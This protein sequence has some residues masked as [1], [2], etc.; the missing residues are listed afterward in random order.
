MNF[1]FTFDHQTDDK[2]I[3]LSG[4][5]HH[6]CGMKSAFSSDKQ[7]NIIT[8]MKVRAKITIPSQ[9]VMEGALGNL[10]SDF[11]YCNYEVLSR[12][13]NYMFVINFSLQHTIITVSLSH[14]NF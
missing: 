3:F 8:T 1:K 6:P 9:S 10:Y 5:T 14:S 7:D 2:I 4:F 11:H 12:L 13:R